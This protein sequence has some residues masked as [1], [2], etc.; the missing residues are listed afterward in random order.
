MIY[1]LAKHYVSKEQ[2]KI[3]AFNTFMAGGTAAGKLHL[4]KTLF[5]SEKFC[6]IKL[7]IQKIEEYF[8]LHQQ[9]SGQLKLSEIT[10]GIIIK[11]FFAFLFIYF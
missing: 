9:V 6:C 2:V 3:V 11:D 8:Y 5:Q 1:K 7:W 10:L 4:M